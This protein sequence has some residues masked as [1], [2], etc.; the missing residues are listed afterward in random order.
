M[1]QADSVDQKKRELGDLFF[2]L[3]NAAR[4]LGAEAEETLR[5]TN[6]SFYERFTTMERLCKNRG[7]NFVDLPI[8][9]KELLWGEVKAMKQDSLVDP[10]TMNNSGTKLK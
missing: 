6:S 3:V 5:Q 7:L 1:D 9:E 8:G 2:S 10:S 4:W